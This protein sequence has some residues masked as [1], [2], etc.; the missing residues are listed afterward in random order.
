MIIRLKVFEQTLSIVDTKSVPRKGSKDYLVLQFLFSSDWKDL[1]KLCYLQHGDVSQPIDVVD[2]L[3]EVPEWFTQQDSFDVTLFG[4]SG[5][6]E[7]PTNVVSLRLEKSNTLWAQDAPEPQPSWLA[8][9][10]ELNNHPPVPGENGYW[11]LWDTDSGAYV[12]SELPLPVRGG[13]TGGTSDHSALYNRDK[14]DQHPMSA[15]TGLVEALEGKQPTGDYLTHDNLQSAT[16][17]AL[18][19]A[20]ASGEFDGPAGAGMDITGATVGQIAKITAVDDSGKPTAWEAVDF[21]SGGGSE[22]VKVADVTYNSNKEVVV[23]SI[24]YESGI[25]T[26]ANHGLQD[27]ENV[28]FVPNSVYEY[29]PEKYMPGGTLSGTEYKVTNATENTFA[30]SGVTMTAKQDIDFT[31]WHLETNDNYG[32]SVVISNLK[33]MN[34]VKV[35]SYGKTVSFPQYSTC[36]AEVNNVL[37]TAGA[38]EGKLPNNHFYDG[39]G[40]IGYEIF[41]GNILGCCETV[42]TR[43]DKTHIR[44]EITALSSYT[45][46]SSDW[47]INSNISHAVAIAECLEFSKHPTELKYWNFSPANGYRIEVYTK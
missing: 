15:V 30:L 27:G 12:E 17:A 37:Y 13:G 31:K 34:D 4:K 22:W 26:S 7:V 18:A 14:A 11:L 21:P 16:N 19:Q 20:K 45:K 1:G 38:Y 29:S 46:K 40:D 32:S 36:A 33:L 28:Y 42:I 41:R 5:S 6:K 47:G 43:L 23:E 10:I 24:D 2:G 9:V 3:V 8:K 39:F 44:S 35:I 25:I